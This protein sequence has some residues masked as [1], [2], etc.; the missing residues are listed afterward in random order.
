[1]EKIKLD[2]LGQFCAAIGS[3]KTTCTFSV[4][5]YLKEPLNPHKL[6]EAT[7]DIVKRLPH[8]NVRSY[9]GFMQ[10]FN[11]VV[12]EPIKIEKENNKRPC[13]FFV[14]QSRLLRVIYGERHFTLEVFHSV[15]DGRS[16]A[17]VASSLLIRYFE[18]MG[19][20]VSKKGFIDCLSEA[21]EEEAEDAY[22]RYADNRK[23]KPEK[24]KNVYVPKRISE[25]AEFITQKFDLAEIKSKAKAQG[26]TVSEYI[27]AHIFKELAIQRA[28]D[29]S[30]KP[31][32]T[33]VPIDCRV[34]LNSKSLRN[35]ASHMIVKMP[36]SSDFAEVALN[37]KK[38]LAEITPDY[39]LDKISDVER[40]SR[41]GRF[42]P[43]FIKKWIIKGVGESTISA[44]CS[45]D[46]S[47]LGVIKLPEEIQCKV[48]MYTFA[49]GEVSNM[50]YQVACVATGDILT[51]TTTTACGTEM[52]DKIGKAL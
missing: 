37:I 36:E 48:E 23:S 41:L 10:Y 29:G 7:N 1:M 44:G 43:L 42:V 15:C 21:H 18:I 46:F 4:G 22:A 24:M 9:N 8:M 2:H 16:L 20:K 3:E 51:L 40:M 50:P 35:F 27:L 13:R 39:V 11:Q 25:E 32:T 17:M 31:I 34:F 26:A 14:K 47:N 12:D 45:M 19:V 49:L 6:Q 38:Q 28:N 30:D 52:V 5:I 33:N